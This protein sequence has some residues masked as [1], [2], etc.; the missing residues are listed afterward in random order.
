MECSVRDKMKAEHSEALE[1][2][3]EAGGTKLMRSEDAAVAFANVSAAAEALLKHCTE[4]G[5]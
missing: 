4:H 3:T 1:Q 5:C 2:W